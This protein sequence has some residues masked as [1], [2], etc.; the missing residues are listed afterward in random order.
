[1]DIKSLCFLED[2]YHSVTY[3]LCSYF[4]TGPNKF[5]SFFFFPQLH[6]Q[7]GG[8]HADI[9]GDGVL[10]HVQVHVYFVFSSFFFLAQVY[11]MLG[12]N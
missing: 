11:T 8:L 1:M 3:A 10:D 9:N 12:V 4:L 7:E 5:Y 2:Q 6:L